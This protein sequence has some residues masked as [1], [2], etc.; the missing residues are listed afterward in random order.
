MGQELL[1]LFDASVLKS[2]KEAGDPPLDGSKGDL[3]MMFKVGW[4]KLE[5]LKEKN[6]DSLDALLFAAAFKFTLDFWIE[7]NRTAILSDDKAEETKET[8]SAVSN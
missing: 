7:Q 5:E 8:E 3:H 6:A 1:D 4:E 2:N